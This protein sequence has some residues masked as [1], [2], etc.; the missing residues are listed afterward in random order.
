M[1]QNGDELKWMVKGQARYRAEYLS[2]KF[3]EKSGLDV[4]IWDLIRM[5][6]VLETVG[7]ADAI[8][9]ECKNCKERS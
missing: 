9:G 2:L 7:R 8:Q 1:N 4:E 3:G 5:Q 6:V